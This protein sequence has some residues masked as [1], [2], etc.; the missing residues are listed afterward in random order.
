MFVGHTLIKILMAYVSKRRARDKTVL[1]GVLKTRR[2]LG[3]LRHKRWYRIP[4]IHMPLR[5]FTHLAFYQPAVFGRE[6]K[7]IQY[8]AR[9][10]DRH[11]RE[12]LALLPDE[13]RH[14]RAHDPYIKIHVG[15]VRRLRRPIVN[16]MPRRV[17]F[18]FTTPQRLRAARNILDLFGVP[19]TEEIMERH[20]RRAGIHAAA[21]VYCMEKEKRHRLDFAVQCVRGRIAIECD[22]TKAH[23]GWRQRARDKAKDA[24][25]QR[26][27]WTVFRFGEE[28]ILSEG[29]AC[30]A[31]VAR[32]VKKLGGETL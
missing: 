8:Y 3:I 20:L 23:A 6:G 7:R 21:Q 22:N 29:K 2:D 32:A 10:Q 12:R 31:R 4:A 28:E 13:P 19:N 5:P 14:P 30:A 1:V 24:F 9:V 25:L 26:H 17:Y 18:G 15:A 16:A 11:V 27:G